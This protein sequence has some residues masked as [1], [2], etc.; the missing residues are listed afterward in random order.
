ME[1]EVAESADLWIPGENR[2]GGSDT[3]IAPVRVLTDFTIFQE[4]SGRIVP[5]ESLL[6]QD[7]ESLASS[8]YRA[9]GHAAVW[10][11]DDSESESESES[12]DNSTTFRHH[13]QIAVYLSAILDVSIHHVEDSRPR[14][15]SLDP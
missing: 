3:G 14:H 7:P 11:E 10:F 1:N 13:G 8:N 4:P 12:E 9:V 15:F 5:F 2:I 6:G